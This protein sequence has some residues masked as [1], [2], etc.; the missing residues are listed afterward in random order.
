MP[1]AQSVLRTIQWQSR[2]IRPTLASV[3]CWK[4]NEPG[5]IGEVVE[6]TRKQSPLI[7]FNTAKNEGGQLS[8]CPFLA[9]GWSQR[10]GSRQVAKWKTGA[11]T[12]VLWPESQ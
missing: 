9:V 6:L 4:H 2:V 3:S 11:H 7:R 5:S 1:I 12:K 8:H 10:I